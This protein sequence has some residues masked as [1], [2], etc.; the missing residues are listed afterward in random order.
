MHHHG[1]GHPPILSA[2]TIIR[3]CPEYE[4]RSVISSVALFTATIT[5]RREAGFDLAH[6]SFDPTHS[7]ADIIAGLCERIPLGAQLLVRQPVLPARQLLDAATVRDLPPA[8]NEIIARTL[9]G[10]TLL[11]VVLTDAQL[12]AAGEAL[13]LEM[14]GPDSTP[15]MRNRRAPEQAMAMWSVYTQAFC[16]RAEA[17]AL[18]A[19]FQAW[20]LLE[21]VKPLPF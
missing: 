8:D 12:A 6:A 18:L 21:R 14:L 1:P 10:T 20:R 17:R 7:R 4:L 5:G 19:A 11:P 15:L 9:P 16:R 2:L 3:T 13:G